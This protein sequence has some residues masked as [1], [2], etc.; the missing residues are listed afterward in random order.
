MLTQIPAWKAW[1]GLCIVHNKTDNSSA[2]NVVFKRV[3]QISSAC[4]LLTGYD[5]KKMANESERTSGIRRIR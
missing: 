5:G 4:C 3:S 2:T 1:K